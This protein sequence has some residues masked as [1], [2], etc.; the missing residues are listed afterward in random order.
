[1]N[2]AVKSGASWMILCSLATTVAAQ[3]LPE[4]ILA[5]KREPDDARRLQC[6][7]QEVAKFPV[8]PEQAFGLSPSRVSAAQRQSASPEAKK[9]EPESQLKSLTAKV[10]AL[11]DR[12]YAGFVVTFDNGQVWMQ[13]EDDS[14]RGVHVGDLVTIKPGV[15]GSFWL[16][17]PSGWATKIHRV[18]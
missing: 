10:V 16:V 17:G 1:M 13:Y 12:P 6:Y 18:K 2:W 11:R 9:T 14:T 15:L 4:S 3:V 5:C 8:T 7:D